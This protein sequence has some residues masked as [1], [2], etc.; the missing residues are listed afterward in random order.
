MLLLG[1]LSSTLFYTDVKEYP[2][3][4]VDQLKETLSSHKPKGNS[5]SFVKK[6]ISVQKLGKKKTE[7]N[8]IL[9]KAVNDLHHL[10]NI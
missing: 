3:K 6:V 9:E 2:L 5:V 7:E 1:L 10:G 4:V 8:I